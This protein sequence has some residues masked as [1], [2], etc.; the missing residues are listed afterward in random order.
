MGKISLACVVAVFL[1]GAS[2]AA[3]L[4]P[5]NRGAV[6]YHPEQDTSLTWRVEAGEPGALV[7]CILRGYGDDAVGEFQLKVGE[8]RT[9]QWVPRRPQGITTSSS[10]T[11]SSGLAWSCSR[12]IKAPRMP[13]FRSTRPCPGWSGRIHCADSLVQNLRRSGIAMARERLNWSQITR[14]GSGGN[15]RLAAIRK[16]A[17]RLCGRRRGSS[18]DVPRRAGLAGTRGQVPG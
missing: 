11:A 15:G 18:G 14:P 2:S 4:Q 7:K 8:D 12:P 10:R 6:L 17:Q 16:T 3:T 5:A 9:I 1:P 13:S